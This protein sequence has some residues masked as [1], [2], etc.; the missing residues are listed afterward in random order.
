[1]RD[2]GCSKFFITSR[3]PISTKKIRPTYD[4]TCDVIA[5]KTVSKCLARMKGCWDPKF[6]PIVEG[7]SMIYGDS[8][9]SLSLVSCTLGRF[10]YSSR[11]TCGG[12]VWLKPCV[13]VSGSTGSSRVPQYM[14][15]WSMRSLW[16]CRSSNYGSIQ[17]RGVI[18]L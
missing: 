4:E 7:L 8:L 6:E 5:V 10:P 9:G 17:S 13:Q 18:F 16:M 3:V 15:T 1:M 11:C 14:H 12:H 2:E